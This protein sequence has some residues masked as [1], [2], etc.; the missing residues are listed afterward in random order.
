MSAV[1]PKF[2]DT[3]SAELEADKAS[4]RA[5]SAALP[6]PDVPVVLLAGTKKDPEFPG[7]PQE[8]DLKLEKISCSPR[9]LSKHVLVPES[10]HSIQDDAPAL[11]IQAIREV[12]SDQDRGVPQSTPLA[13]SLVCPHA[14]PYLAFEAWPS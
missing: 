4:G 5:L 13:C 2:T 9:S 3:Q 12:A 8:Q 1:K 7:N 14:G 10:R 11:V 6:L